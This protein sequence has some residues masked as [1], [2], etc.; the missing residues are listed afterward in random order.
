MQ[1]GIDI[2]NHQGSMDLA[3]VLKQTKTDFVICKS[4]EGLKFVDKF[5]DKFMVIAQNAGKQVGFY[6]FARPEWNS[7]KAEAEFFLRQTK[8]YFGKGI[9]VLDW[10]SSGKS[11]VKWAKEW[12]DYIYDKTG[13]KPVIYMSESVVNAY[14]WKAVADTGYG[15]WVARYRD[16]NID[17]NYDMSTCGKKPVVKWWSFYMMWQ[18]TS[19]GRL[20][21]YSGNLDCDVFYGDSKSWDAYVK[22]AQITT[23]GVEVEKIYAYTN[24]A[25]ELPILRKGAQGNAV[26]LVQLVVGA[27][28]DG[29]WGN[30]TDSKVKV[31]ETKYKLEPDGLFDKAD[32][33]VALDWLATV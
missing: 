25:A 7:A 5:C 33:Q 22:C 24:L 19:V 16:Y 17:R 29:S 20:D 21:G 2:S 9:P 8:G 11:N 27:Q 23:G 28:I 1:N 13:V 32:W 3:K 15:L 14:N 30:E 26:K 4:T 18:W 31:W 10:E 12:L 6:H